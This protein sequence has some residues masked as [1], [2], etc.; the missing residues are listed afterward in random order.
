MLDVDQYILLF[1]QAKTE[2]MEE[3]KDYIKTSK[4]P[5]RKTSYD[6]W[7]TVYLNWAIQR[8]ESIEKTGKMPKIYLSPD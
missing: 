6:E 2:E 8:E 1:I 7:E 5:N 4:L 3:F